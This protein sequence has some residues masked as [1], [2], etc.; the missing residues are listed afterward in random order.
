M[1]ARI[2]RPRLSRGHHS[3]SQAKSYCCSMK[4]YGSGRVVTEERFYRQLNNA[5]SANIQKNIST[6]EYL[7]VICLLLGLPVVARQALWT[8]LHAKPKSCR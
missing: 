5:C 1:R 8:A 2:L 3:H 4:Q 6:K 7:F